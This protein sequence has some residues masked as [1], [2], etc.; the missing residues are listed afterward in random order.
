MNNYIQITLSI[1]GAISII[2]GGITMI[3][4]LFTPYKK[5]RYTVE[6]HTQLLEK[7][8]KRINETEE[9]NKIICK[10]LLVLIEHEITGNSIDKLKST[11]QELQEYLINK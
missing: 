10:T 4:R 1:F 5:M 7:D 11:K 3:I 8:N 9:S 6:K 2:G